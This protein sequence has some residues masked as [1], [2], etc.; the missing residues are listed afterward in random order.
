MS[1]AY[2]FLEG[3]EAESKDNP[4]FVIV[5]SETGDKYARLVEQKGLRDGNLEWLVLMQQ[6]K[7]AHGDTLKAGPLP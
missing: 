7:C 2:F 5:D 3:V 1:M 6:P 4:M